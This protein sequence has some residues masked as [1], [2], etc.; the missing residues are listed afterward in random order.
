MQECD[1]Q[2]DNGTIVSQIDR[3]LIDNHTH[4]QNIVGRSDIVKQELRRKRKDRDRKK[5]KDSQ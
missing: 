5:K 3:S 1:D 4:R 2:R